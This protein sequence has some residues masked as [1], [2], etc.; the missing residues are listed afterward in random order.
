LTMKSLHKKSY[1][2]P[3][4]SYSP[5]EQ[6]PALVRNACETATGQSNP[7]MSQATIKFAV[8]AECQKVFRYA[9]PNSKLH[10]VVSPDH[11]IAFYSHAVDARTPLE[12]MK[13]MKLPPNLTVMQK[14]TRFHPETDTMFGGVTAFTGESSI[15]TGIRFR[16]KYRGFNNRP[17]WLR[18][19]LEHRVD[20]F[21]VPVDEDKR[22]YRSDY[23]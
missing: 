18:Y 20:E 8:L 6:V 23:Y 5:P 15:V 12:Q 3:T 14:Y 11:L 10:E 13:T 4:P 17:E 19:N 2:R 7:D 22:D 16:K 21:G 1:L 9:V